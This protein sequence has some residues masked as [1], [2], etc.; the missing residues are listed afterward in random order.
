MQEE[1]YVQ[2]FVMDV[3]YVGSNTHAF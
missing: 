2:T 3:C 1:W